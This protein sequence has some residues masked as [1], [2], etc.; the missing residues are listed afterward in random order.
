MA[1]TGNA[2]RRLGWKVQTEN[3]AVTHGAVGIAA[4][5]L[6]KQAH[7]QEFP[8]ALF[9]ERN[10][11]RTSSAR[12]Q[13]LESE[14][15]LTSV[16]DLQM[17][18]ARQK[19]ANHEMKKRVQSLSARATDA[20]TR[21]AELKDELNVARDEI[22]LQQDDKHS[23][24]KSLDALADENG[25][26]AH[27]LA[28]SNAAVED[29][30]SKI[31]QINKELNVAQLARRDLTAA[32]VEVQERHQR[33]ADDLK[34][35]R[36]ERTKLAT[37]L[38]GSQE[39]YRAEAKKTKTLETERNEL[40]AALDRTRKRRQT[41]AQKLQTVESECTKLVAVL[42]KITE[43]HRVEV[44]RLTSRLDDTA[45]RADVAENILGKL[46]EI[47]LEKF[48]LLQMSIGT[49]NGVIHDLERSRTKLVDATKIL[50][51]IFEMRDIAL[52][53]GDARI[54]SL[55]VRIAEL[56]AQL[57]SSRQWERLRD[58]DGQTANDGL[59]LEV[60]VAP[61]LA[62]KSDIQLDCSMVTDDTDN[63][64]RGRSAWPCVAN[65]TLS[66][67]VTF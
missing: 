57:Q 44:S 14:F 48:G 3:L 49:K 34:V 46:R 5:A 42:A 40:A 18:L 9:C 6:A 26:L 66:A 43:K 12:R 55:T 31:E 53:R 25:R 16:R 13:A 36:L 39:G 58:L 2:V 22:L 1:P 62:H 52:K 54:R 67:T 32:L 63:A 28:E 38:N 27:G 4:L 11:E 41:E 60:A 45:A 35:A 30:R 19:L 61:D 56:E 29:A 37:A 20:E 59:Q 33:Q 24:Q 50:L 47:L 23:L 64:A 51:G 10:E 8:V 21:Y 65:A 17:Q 7:G 15:E